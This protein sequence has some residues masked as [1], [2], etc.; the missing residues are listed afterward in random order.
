MDFI[1]ADLHFFH[2]GAIQFDGRPFRTVQEMN[3]RLIE[4]WNKVVKA[5]DT[6]YVLGDM[7]FKAKHDEVIQVLEQLN[8][9]I[10]VVF[11]NHEKALMTN[12]QA[13]TEYI[14]ETHHYLEVPYEYKGE[15]HRLVLSHYPIPLFNGHFRDNHTHL[16]GH[17]HRTEEYLMTHYQQLMNF[18]NSNIEGIHRMFNVGCMI[19]EINYT[20]IPLSSAI[21]LAELQSI[22]FYNQYNDRYKQKMP[23]YDEFRELYSFHLAEPNQTPDKENEGEQK[24]HD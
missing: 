6:V 3:Q 13:I 12:N 2:K 5:E 24:I 11:G 16:Y 18:H 20:P 23:S 9:K 19:P 14:H 7:F 1:I 8:G 22:E 15:H 4:N 21:Q 17:V 10:I